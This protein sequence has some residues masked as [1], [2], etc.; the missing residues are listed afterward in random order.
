MVSAARY[1]CL[2]LLLLAGCPRSC[3]EVDTAAEEKPAPPADKPAD[4]PTLLKPVGPN[5][6]PMFGGTVGRNFANEVEKG[7]AATWSTAKGKEKNIK[8]SPSSAT[9][10]S[11]ARSLPAGASSSAPTTPARATRRSRATRA[12]SCASPRTT[13]SSFGRSS[14]T[15]TPAKSTP[16]CSA[17]CPTR[18]W[19]ATGSTTSAIGASWSAPTSPA[20]PRPPARAR[21]SGRST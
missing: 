21:S 15:R 7:I 5:S 9:T 4:A 17:S 19:T 11:P 2:S 1:F 3:C 12:S 20:T 18:P 13:A 8:W 10:R 6:V 14:T 16:S